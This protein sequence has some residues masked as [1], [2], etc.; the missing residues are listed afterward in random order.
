MGAI[1]LVGFIPVFQPGKEEARSRS[2]IS[3]RKTK[4]HKCPLSRKKKK[5]K[6][7]ERREGIERCLR[8]FAESIKKA[9]TCSLS[10]WSF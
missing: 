8:R 6:Q 5:K 1:I 9:L 10:E 7:E 3:G 2:G 4:K